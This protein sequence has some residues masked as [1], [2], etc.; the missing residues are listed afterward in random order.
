MAVLCGMPT[1]QYSA[2]SARLSVHRLF[3]SCIRRGLVS[4]YMPCCRPVSDIAENLTRF[5]VRNIEARVMSELIPTVEM[6]TRN[7]VQG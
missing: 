3:T 4:R 2:R 5:L 1:I 7:P 6:E